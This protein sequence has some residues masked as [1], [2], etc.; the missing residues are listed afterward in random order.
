MSLVTQTR[1]EPSANDK[2]GDRGDA[3]V[4]GLPERSSSDCPPQGQGPV[5]LGEKT[6][7]CT[8]CRNGGAP[9]ETA[10]LDDTPSGWVLA[11]GVRVCNCTSVLGARPE[12][13]RLGPAFNS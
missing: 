6:R 5:L 12:L 2:E 7:V 10:R 1:V 13:L 8:L 3:G 9:N 4:D 11:T